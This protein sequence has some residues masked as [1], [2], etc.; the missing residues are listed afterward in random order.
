MPTL[1]RI[2]IMV[3]L[4]RVSF[5]TK[6]SLQIPLIL[7]LLLLNILAISYFLLNPT[8][9]SSAQSSPCQTNDRNQGLISGLN[10]SG[11]FGNLSG[12]CVLD[13]KAAYAVF[14]VPSYESLKSIYFTQSKIQ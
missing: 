3:K 1:K 2:F 14:K 7:I 5:A 6:K 10:V 4:L 8:K 13:P 11:Y 9:H 12:Q